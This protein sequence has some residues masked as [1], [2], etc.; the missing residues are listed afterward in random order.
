MALPNT[1][2]SERRWLP[3]MAQNRWPVVTPQ[4][5]RPPRRCARGA[6]AGEWRRT[7]TKMRHAACSQHYSMP[8]LAVG[9]PLPHPGERSGG[10]GGGRGALTRTASTMASAA[11]MPRAG[12]SSWLRPGRPKAQMARN[13]FSS[14]RNWRVRVG[15][16]EG[17]GGDAGGRRWSARRLAAPV[18]PSASADRCRQRSSGLTCHQPPA[19]HP[20]THLQ[21][22]AVVLAHALLHRL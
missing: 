5:A 1:V 16:V 7:R 14:Q 11:W 20:R 10:G 17:G 8:A 3:T 13:P 22:G 18:A 2:Y 4:H 12:P 19:S 6:R 9:L 21:E 15:G